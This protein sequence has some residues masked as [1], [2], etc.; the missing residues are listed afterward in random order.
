MSTPN[1]NVSIV[2]IILTTLL[3]ICLFTITLFFIIIPAFEK[4]I[5]DRKREMICELTNAA[6]SVLAELH[7][8]EQEGDLTREQAQRRAIER[9]RFLRYGDERKDYFWITDMEPRMIVH[10]YLQELNGQSLVDYED[11][12]G[13]KLFLEFV[14]VVRENEHGYVD[15]MWQWKDDDTRIVPKLSYVKGFHPWGWIIGTGIYI[16]DV[17]EE[18]AT[19]TKRIIL[20]SVGITILIALLLT[21]TTLQSLAIEKNKRQ[22]EEALRISREKYKILVESATEG[23]IMIVDNKVFYSNN[24]SL[25][26]LGYQAHEFQ[27]IPL[28]R[29]IPD[30]PV[31]SSWIDFIDDKPIPEQYSAQLIRKDGTTLN[32]LLSTA[33]ITFAGKQAIILTAK[34]FTSQQQLEEQLGESKE[35]FETLVNNISMGVFRAVFGKKG[36]II[37][38]NPAA[39]QIFGF[40]EYELLFNT[41]FRDLIQDEDDCEQFFLELDIN[42]SIKNRIICIQRKDGSILT[43]SISA[44]VT[45]GENAKQRYFDAIVEDITAQ[46]KS[47]EEREDLIVELQ[48]ALLYLNQPIR[49]SLRELTACGMNQSI[50]KA[51]A[52][53]TKHNTTAILVQSENNSY[54]GIVTDS[55]IR[56][57]VVANS[58]DFER[59][60]FEIMSSP[61]VT[62]SDHA[63]LYEAAF[64]MQENAIRHLAVRDHSGKIVSLL[65]EKEILKVHRYSSAILIQEIQ[66][67]ETLEEIVEGRE[68]LPRLVKALIDSGANVRSI[69][70]IITI[71][72][73]T[74]V[75][76]ILNRALKELGQ[77]PTHFAFIALGSEGR[78]EQTLYT[79]QDNAI[80]FDDVAPDQLE[81]VQSY[82]LELAQRLCTELDQAGYALC[83]GE[84]M[85]MNPRWC[86]PLSVWKDYFGDWIMNADPQALLDVKIFFDYR[87][88]FGAEE[89]VNRLTSHLH[90]VS[91]GKSAF[92]QHLA[93]NTLQF[94]PP[95][96]FFG[97]IVVQTK[98][99]HPETFDIKEAMLPI[100]DFARV[101]A[102]KY[103]IRET[104]TLDRYEKIFEKNILTKSSYENAVQ[105]YN[106]MMQLRFKHQAAYLNENKPPDNFVNPKSLTNIE[107]AML[108][109]MFSHITQFQSR[110]SSD[111]TGLA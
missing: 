38:A 110:L 3:T 23:V 75:Y 62:I 103:R 57:R 18:I 15:Y 51:A 70:R 81:Q 82:F 78:E 4:T 74:I 73:D 68:R 108:K 47:E 94:K 77:P 107:Q 37:E 13:K 54:I 31:N 111:F 27:N 22:A 19:I 76:K 56:Q 21:F 43:A 61:L 106:F 105:A 7:A 33:K 86:Q 85:A 90:K 36:R 49:H 12:S 63:L 104:N 88:L 92:Y 5:L 69:T 95:L 53:M 28:E 91:E 72:S 55:D 20:I 64:V 8:E 34:D 46:K 60:V 89:L 83:K 80:I 25:E 52:L 26:M 30:H 44:V 1:S 58:V 14:N 102:L 100:V 48:T 6:W 50:R 66:N 2:R 42:H 99:G 97:K 9:I 109:K 65:T 79:D 59:P 45:T 101:Y 71:A 84:V 11:P 39:L 40:Q 93:L 87:F 16:E 10:P 24:T 29:I 35:K 98:D 96:G 67:A 32:V 41:P 17:K